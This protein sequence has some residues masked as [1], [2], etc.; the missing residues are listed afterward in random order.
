[1][2]TIVIIILL[3]IVVTKIIN[4]LAKKKATGYILPTD[5]PRPISCPMAPR[6]RQKKSIKK[7][8]N[9][10]LNL[11]PKTWDEDS[12]MEDEFQTFAPTKKR[13]EDA[14]TQNVNA[15][16]QQI[17]DTNPSRKKLG[18]VG[19]HNMVNA[20]TFVDQSDLNV[21]WGDS[22]FRYM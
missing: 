12:L 6:T 13:W 14:R 11:F 2:A 19:I 1:M 21:M 18:Y 5:I 22:E 15:S 3:I 10:E 8:D 20:P 17:L 9:D 16:F 7:L 4:T